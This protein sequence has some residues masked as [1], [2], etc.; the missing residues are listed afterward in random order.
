MAD[1]TDFIAYFSIIPDPRVE[2]TRKHRLI[3]ILFIGV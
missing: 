2:R 3:D 1:T